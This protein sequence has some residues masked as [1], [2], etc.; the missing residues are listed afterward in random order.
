MTEQ[1]L[2]NAWNERCE[3]A[4]EEGRLFQAALDF[5]TLPFDIR[6][7]RE[8]LKERQVTKE[9]LYKSVA[10]FD[11]EELITRVRARLVTLEMYGVSE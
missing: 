4:N 2:L 6:R 9:D 8:F 7:L 3:E 1:E 5:S 11:R 10:E